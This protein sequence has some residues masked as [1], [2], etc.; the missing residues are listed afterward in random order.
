MKKEIHILELAEKLKGVNAHM[1]KTFLN[2]LLIKA[3]E[4]KKP[5]CDLKFISKLGMKPTNKYLCNTIYGWIKYEKSIPLN[6]LAIATKLSGINFRE[7]EKKI[8]FIST[9]RTRIPFHSTIKIDKQLGTIIGHILGD[10]SIDKKYKQVFFS[11]SDKELLKEFSYCMG[12]IFNIQPRIWMQ[13]SPDF[14]NTKWDKRLSNI[15]ELMEGRNGGLFYPT[16]CGLILNK[17]F[18]DFAIG[19]EK[20]ITFKIISANKEFKKGLIRAFYD[21]EASVGKKNIRLFQDRK[22]ILE[23]FKE[24][25]KEFNITTNNIKSYIKK[26][27]KRFYLDIFK[28][29]N[30]SKFRNE[31]GLTSPKKSSRLE[32]MC[33]IKNFKNSK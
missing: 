21:D 29:S 8:G 27:K 4:N 31:I 1:D 23:A 33:I 12:E 30:F 6:K 15:N 26:D 24:M 16:I 13:K 14:G 2:Y 25:L 10:G 11:N 7:V 20:K 5:H 28:K 18:D 9:G 22:D 17:I 32:E 19:K 3:S